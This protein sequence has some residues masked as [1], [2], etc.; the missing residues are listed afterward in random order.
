MKILS[1]FLCFLLPAGILFLTGCES[2]QSQTRDSGT[3]EIKCQYCYD[4]VTHSQSYSPK[5][6]TNQTTLTTTKHVC[7]DCGE[8]TIYQESGTAMFKCPKCA[9]AGVPCASCKPVR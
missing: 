5:G 2:T 9:P 7:K 6:A 4:I 8:I 3:V 1:A